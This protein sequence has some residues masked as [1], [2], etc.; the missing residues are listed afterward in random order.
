[1]MISNSKRAVRTRGRRV[2]ADTDVAPEAAEL[3]FEAGDVAELVAEVTGEAVEVTAEDS[4]DAV[5]F[6]IGD[7]SYT[8][9][10][11]GTEEAVA[12][13][14]RITRGR[15]SIAA[16]TRMRGRK[17]RTIRKMPKRR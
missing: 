15:R 14:T 3:L 6:D 2:M 11:E 5:T 17:G 9:E 4:G 10:A 1:M 16:S 12:S 7:E 13:A 8:V